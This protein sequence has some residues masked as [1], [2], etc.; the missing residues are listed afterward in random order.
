MSPADARPDPKH[1]SSGRSG[2]VPRPRLGDRR[3]APMHTSFTCQHDAC[4]SSS[5][6]GTSLPS[7]TS[8]RSTT[9][10]KPSFRPAFGLPFRPQPLAATSR[11]RTRG[12]RWPHCS[13]ELER[14]ISPRP[15]FRKKARG[16]QV[17]PPLQREPAGWTHPPFA[18]GPSTFD[19]QPLRLVPRAALALA[20]RG[21]VILR[22]RALAALPGAVAAVGRRLRGGEHRCR[23]RERERTREREAG[24]LLPHSVH[25]LPRPNGPLACRP[26]ER[27]DAQRS[28]ARRRWEAVGR[29]FPSRSLSQNSASQTAR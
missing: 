2:I 18:S 3:T 7:G 20:R 17:W 8:S 25:L 16:G 27:G 29:C 13:G 6:T 9:T 23:R 12:G 24:E 10:G 28:A 19:S 26:G 11:R 14:C 1:S 21:P 22:P 5:S 15:Q 4:R